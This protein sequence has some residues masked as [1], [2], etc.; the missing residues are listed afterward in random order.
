MFVVLSGHSPFRS[1]A[2]TG[3]AHDHGVAGGRRDGRVP[4]SRA[5]NPPGDTR[6]QEP[7]VVLFVHRDHFPTII[8]KCPW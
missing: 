5:V 2:V 6:A 1:I 7:T 4:Y 3:L 8:R